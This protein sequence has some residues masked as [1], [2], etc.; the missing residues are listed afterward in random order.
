MKVNKMNLKNKKILITGGTGFLGG[1]VTAKFM[2]G[3]TSTIDAVN[4]KEA[5]LRSYRE[6][7]KITRG[8]DIVVHLAAD[9]GGIEYNRKNPG[10]LFHD[11]MLMSLNVLEACRK[12]AV[13]KIV[14][15]GS[16]CGYPKFTKV[17]F[18]ESNL[19]DGYP[20][21][22]NAPYGLAKRNTLTLAQS[23]RKQYGTNAIYLLIVNLY[24][25]HDHFDDE[26]SHVI[27]AIIKKFMDAKE[28]DKK[29]VILWGTGKPTREFLYVED[30][31]EAILL[32]TKLYDKPMPINIGAGFEI[33]IKELAEDV[34][35]IVG[36]QGNIVWDESKPDGQP[37]RCLDVSKAMEH[38]NFEARTNMKDGL[39]KTI[40]WYIQSKE[41]PNG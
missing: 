23:Y 4:S 7:E 31:A 8:V 19:W 6:T 29:E 30:A 2:S 33:S 36:Y 11:N 28:Q 9:C 34:R 5:D 14:L 18:R 10:R 15:L 35:S 17:P 40:D 38:I 24:G 26:K 32:A 37:R 41:D 20:E 22:T 13:K 27:P 3:E 25:P 21:E 12:N 16:V 1:F 39:R